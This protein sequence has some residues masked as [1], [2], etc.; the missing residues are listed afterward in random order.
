MLIPSEGAET[1]PAELK[2]AR[3]ALHVRTASILLNDDPTGRAGFSFPNHQEIS[4]CI[5]AC[6][7]FLY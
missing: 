4:G 2:F 3:L 7:D 5:S 6:K 1:M